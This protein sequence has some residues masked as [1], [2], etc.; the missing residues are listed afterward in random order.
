MKNLE[1]IP[2]AF[3]LAIVL[4]ACGSA[5]AEPVEELIKPG[6]RIGS[7]LITTGK[8]EE[9]TYSWEEGV[10]VK[11]ESAEIYSCSF[12]T[13]EKVNASAGIFED[14]SGKD[15]DTLWSRHLYRMHINDQPV[16]LPAFGSIDTFHPLVGTM[17][18][19]DVVIAASTPG[20]IVIRSEFVVDGKPFEDTTILTFSGP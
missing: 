18:H 15:V 11:Q 2:L 14:T 8:G 20:E 4:A 13:G 12:A 5:E 16:N 9:V 19:W 7:F 1:F 6:D 10:C 17:R 3:V